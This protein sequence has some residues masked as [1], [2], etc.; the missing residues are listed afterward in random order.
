[1][2][3]NPERINKTCISRY[4][5]LSHRSNLLE[6][7]IVV[8]II[9]ATGIFKRFEFTNELIYNSGQSPSRPNGPALLGEADN[10]STSSSIPERARNV[11]SQHPFH[12]DR[13][14]AGRYPH[15]TR[16]PWNEVPLPSDERTTGH[17]F[18]DA[19]NR[20]ALCGKTHFIADPI[21]EAGKEK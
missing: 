10:K 1:M 7:L 11:R 13:P 14:N 19:G 9:Q 5:R 17:Y 15:A 4:L 8:T 16:S 20:A 21:G 18:G 12:N 6:K 2:C 3:E